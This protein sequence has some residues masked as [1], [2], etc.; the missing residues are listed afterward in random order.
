MEKIETP[1]QQTQFRPKI[2]YHTCQGGN[3]TFPNF[4]ILFPGPGEPFSTGRK[5]KGHQNTCTWGRFAD[6]L[7][8]IW[9]IFW[10]YFGTILVLF[11]DYLGNILAIFWHYFG[12]IWVL[13]GDYLGNILALF[14]YYLGTIWGLFGDYLR[15]TSMQRDE[16]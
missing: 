3:Q 2:N 4:F 1:G 14:W 8:T 5:V 9:G 12:T 6:Y 15:S 11:G 16:T 10:H 7:G 13:F